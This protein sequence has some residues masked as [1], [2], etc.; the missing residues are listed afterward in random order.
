MF[1][2]SQGQRL[3]KLKSGGSIVA[4]GYE[5]FAQGLDRGYGQGNGGLGR[6]SVLSRLS[7]RDRI[8]NTRPSR[9]RSSTQALS[10]SSRRHPV[11]AK[12]VVIASNRRAFHCRPPLPFRNIP[13]HEVEHAANFLPGVVRFDPRAGLVGS[14]AASSGP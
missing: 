6:Y 2:K 14:N 12:S 13:G 11:S 3:W 4:G 7:I 10:P 1:G 8:K 5:P 9:S